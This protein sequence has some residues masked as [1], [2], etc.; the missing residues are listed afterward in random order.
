MKTV[1]VAA[2]GKVEI[3][4]LDKPKVGPYQALVHTEI[5]ALCNATDGKLV[6]GH[7]PGVDKYPLILGH[8]GAG[9]VEAVG[10]KVRNFK[11]GD[12]VIGGLL[13]EFSDPKYATGWGGFCE[14][15]L[16]NDHDAM[17]ADGVADAEHGWFEC[18]EIQRKVDADIPPEE[19]ALL[20]TWREVYGGFGDFN[21]QK[22]DQILVFGAGPVGL[23]FV[24][25]G[26]LLGLEWIG[27]VDPI[28][29]KREL[30]MK[31]GADAAF[32]AGTDL[33]DLI[34][35]RG[36]KFDA[37]I[38]AVG[39]PKIVNAALPL[40]KMGG[41]VCVYGVIADESI[42]LNKAAGPYNFNLYVHQW[43]TRWRERE[44]QKPLCD[45]I[46]EGKL[47]ASEFVTHTFP[48][49]KINDALAAVKAGEVV[50]CLLKY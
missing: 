41:S 1:A 33:S 17:V 29:H 11:V 4:Q 48:L 6:A 26:K 18:Y 5:A 3:V 14:Y 8:E 38:D 35:A 9:I 16:A 27:V 49:E 40:V 21:L 36:R 45:W 47:K 2:P 42:P 20:C 22:G 28:A 19:A 13:F 25:F 37:V 32:D 50:K 43:P 24:K 23:S 10:E 39:S 30:A 12:R 44:A 7:F 46:R 15:T 31:L 34:K